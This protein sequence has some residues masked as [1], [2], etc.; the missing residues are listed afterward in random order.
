MRKPKGDLR[1]RVRNFFAEVYR[2]RRKEWR[3]RLLA[4]NGRKVTDSAEGY[5]NRGHAFRMVLRVT[6]AVTYLAERGMPAVILPPRRR[7]R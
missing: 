2:D 6:E 5:K 1:M 3:W 7:R 4:A